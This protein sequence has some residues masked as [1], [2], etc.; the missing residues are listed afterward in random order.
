MSAKSAPNILILIS[1]SFV[2][3]GCSKVLDRVFVERHE[4]MRGTLHGLKIGMT[5]KA[6]AMAARRLG[7]QYITPVPCSSQT[8]SSDNFGELSLL[9]SNSEG[10]SISNSKSFV[11]LYLDGGRVT[12]KF[13]SPAGDVLPAAKVGDEM[14]VLREEIEALMK[15]RNDVSLHSIVSRDL[16]DTV[17]L[18]QSER[19]EDIRL[20]AH[21]CWQFEL[22]SA[23]P[24][25]ATYDL[26][27]EKDVLTKISYR[28]A[29]IRTE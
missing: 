16:V 14:A 17:S 18:D 19:S 25:G 1:M 27:F 6:A 4:V 21:A 5:R 12:K 7:S 23:K 13:A 24:T 29:R 8:I 22:A 28:R 15:S 20:S 11:D 3:A 9:L 10:V 26:T 2:G